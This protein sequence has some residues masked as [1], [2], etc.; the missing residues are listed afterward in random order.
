MRALALT[1]VLAVVAAALPA[2]DAPAPNRWTQVD[3]EHAGVRDQHL[4]V[5][6]PFL[7]RALMLGGAPAA[8]NP[9]VMAFDPE[10]RA[11]APFTEAKPEVGKAIPQAAVCDAA[12]KHVYLLVGT[13]IFDLDLEAKAWKKLGEPMKDLGLT[14][15]T[16]SFDP[17][18]NTLLVLG[19]ESAL[20]KVGWMGGYAVAPATGAWTPLTFG[21]EA[22]R[23]AHADRC[24]AL[25][26]LSDLVGRARH[27]WFRDPKGEGSDAERKD[28]AER[29]AA[30]SALPGAASIKAE[31]P[32]VQDLV[33]KKTLLDALKAAR[34]LYRAL[35]ETAEAASPVPPARRHSPP[36]CDPERKLLVLF[37]GDHDDYTTSDTWLLDL[38]KYQWRRAAP[39]QAPAP[40][41]GHALAYLPKS[42]KFA[43]WDG[44]RHN[45]STDYRS[46]QATLLPERELWLYDAGANAWERAAAWPKGE[47]G[48]PVGQGAMGMGFFGYTSQ[49][50]PMALA[51]DGSDRLI[52]AGGGG[53]KT[54]KTVLNGTW[55]LPV[56]A[57]SPSAT[58]AAPV[59]PNSRAERT[60]PFLASF[61][62]DPAPATPLD[63]DNLPA[64]TWTELPAPPRRPYFGWRLCDFGTATWNSDAEEVLHWGGGHCDSS[65]SVVT[66]WSLASNRMALAYDL[67]EPYGSNG[68]GPWP[69]SLMGR[70]WVD[71]HAYRSYGYDSKNKVMVLLRNGVGNGSRLYDPVGM[72][73]LSETVTQPFDGHCYTAHVVPT[74]QGA[75]AW[76]GTREY[77]GAAGRGLWLLERGKGWQELLKP[78]AAP[79][80]HVDNSCS[81]YDSKRDRILLMPGRDHAGTVYAFGMKD[82]ALAKLT[83]GNPGFGQVTRKEAVYVA[84]CDWVLLV[85]AVVKDGVAYHV[86]YD[87]AQDR[88]ILYQA[89]PKTEKMPSPG[90][91][92]MYDAKRGVVLLIT[93]GGGT[94]ALRI[95]PKS[96]TV[97]E[98]E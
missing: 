69:G 87:C 15:L 24:A 14:A 93:E 35:E 39:K 21:D 53:K 85:H 55:M 73:W 58:A 41:A 43:L 50:F 83:P 95:D 28:L 72:R 52:F 9:Y 1:V 81:T 10:A 4:L 92:L 82:K 67:D 8:G 86:V 16:L 62:E 89:G 46:F 12:G 29:C 7:K 91:G 6:S 47:K 49:P 75:V 11:W 65:T 48:L 57:A 59:A 18:R 97:L 37:G 25:N 40:R 66:H 63:L 84:H 5:W 68:G 19:A 98:K 38:E 26:A 42:K 61:C 60:G 20:E 80:C 32:K 56:E 88:W 17:V 45:S 77:M 90:R 54:D 70:P 51:S 27:A 78:G 34:G 22:A 2:G 44:F 79:P 76:A 64:N 71:T 36:A 3:D 94:Y 33:A 96:A 31:I 74:P 23:K 13:Q 30:L